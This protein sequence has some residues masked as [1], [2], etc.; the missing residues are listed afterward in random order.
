[1]VP[2][3]AIKLRDK[4]IILFPNSQS[5]RYLPIG[6]NPSVTKAGENIS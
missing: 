6:L 5:V 1:M 3:L 4:D 2:K